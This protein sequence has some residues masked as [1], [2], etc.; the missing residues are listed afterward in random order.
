MEFHVYLMI[1]KNYP[2]STT[3]GIAKKWKVTNRGICTDGISNQ[4]V[5]LYLNGEMCRQSRLKGEKAK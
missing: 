5:F 3:L 2:I 4:D 1:R